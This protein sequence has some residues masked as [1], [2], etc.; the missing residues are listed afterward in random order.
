MS[1]SK[2]L[3]SISAFLI[4]SFLFIVSVV[5]IFLKHFS[6]FFKQN[7][8]NT[9]LIFSENLVTLFL[10]NAIMKTKDPEVLQVQS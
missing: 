10:S 2:Y 8:I 3:N 7:I 4:C 9:S 5:K 1:Y 6:T